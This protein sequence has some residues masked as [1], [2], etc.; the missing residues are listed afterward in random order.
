MNTQFA[1]VY[2]KL[3]P[4]NELMDKIEDTCFDVDFLIQ[5]SPLG[6][7]YPNIKLR[8]YGSAVNG[9][10]SALDSDLDIILWIPDCKEEDRLVLRQI[11]D[12]LPNSPHLKINRRV[13]DLCHK[14]VLS[15]KHIKNNIDVDIM[16]NQTVEI[17]NSYLLY[18][19]TQIDERFSQMVLLM[20]SWSKKN[21][22]QATEPQ[23]K[24]SSYSIT[25]MILAFLQHLKILPNL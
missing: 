20:K 13:R 19:Y 5:S 3:K 22:F 21:T 18:T 16:V 15:L 9:L 24:L 10:L 17:Y 8:Y 14:T 25:L 11:E 7:K 6:T 1:A 2:E 4:T 12:Y 23:M